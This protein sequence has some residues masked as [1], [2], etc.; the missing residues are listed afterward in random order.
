MVVYYRGRKV[1]ANL[2]DAIADWV[3]ARLKRDEQCVI[4]VRGMTGTGKST[5]SMQLIRRILDR[6]KVDWDLEDMYIYGLDD[7]ARKLK[8]RSKNP[9]LWFDEGSTTINSLNTMTEESKLLGMFFD[10]M[11][12]DHYITIIDV[13]SDKEL[14]GRVTKHADLYIECPKHAPLPGYEA[15]GFFEAFKRTTYR[16]GK[17][18]D[19]S[20]GIGIARPMPK[21]YREPYEA[22]KRER[23]EAFKARMADRILTKTQKKAD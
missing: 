10:T 22:V 21:R 9:I 6:L 17:H 18:Y 5:V 20:V 16:S 19:M 23:A 2:L 4:V 13:P 8:R 15:R 12:I 1:Y 3:V 14:N 11:R 7:L